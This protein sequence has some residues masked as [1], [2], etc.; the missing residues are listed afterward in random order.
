MPELAIDGGKPTLPEFVP[1]SRPCVTEEDIAVVTEVLRGQWLTTGPKIEELE[2][3]FAEAT[4]APY[5]VALNSGTA[6]LHL[7]YEVMGVGV[8]DEVLVPAITFAATAAGAVMAGATPT[9]VDVDENLNIDLDDA[10]RKISGNTKAIAV[11]HMGGLPVDMDSVIALADEFGL[12]VIQDAAHAVA[13]RYKDKRMGEFP[14]AAAYSMHAVK[15]VVSGEGG[16]LTCDDEDK[17]R[18]AKKLRHHGI[19]SSS[20]ERHGAGA[21]Y[22][23]EIDTLGYNYRISDIH[24]ALAI[25]QM[26]RLE[27]DWEKRQRIAEYYD[28][29]LADMEEAGYFKLIR[30]P[31]Y[32][33]HGWHLY[34]LK[35]NPDKYSVGRD[36]IFAALR[37]ENVGTNVH[38][39]PLN[40]HPYYRQRF[41]WKPEDTPNAAELFERII[42][43]P[44]F[45]TLGEEERNG[46]VAAL[47]KVLTYY[48][49]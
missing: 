27:K 1:Y 41:G 17:A 5:A 37:A 4:G 15:P 40:F 23:Y 11:V 47:G 12:V 35:L 49:K 28:T 14:G 8:G 44:M 33:R 30:T 13:A 20:S 45:T 22:Y 39:I 29:A 7:A 19:S 6:A 48:E 32:V 34:I 31:D 18:L 2:A 42:S 10:R 3:V 21:S 25:S 38:Y 16:I 24:A 36:E 43:I 46:V 26:K 9:L